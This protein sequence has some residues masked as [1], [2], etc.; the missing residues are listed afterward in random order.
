MSL[1]DC[2]KRGLIKKDANAHKRAKRELFSAEH[3]LNSAI[4][5]FEIKEYDLTVL[6][7]YN[8]CF[9][10]FRSILF[11]KGFT[12]KSHYCLIESLRFLCKG[13]EKL[14]GL[15]DEFDKI[16]MSRHEIQYRGI[17]SDDDEASYV[18]DFTK[19]LR[20]N[21]NSKKEFCQKAFDRS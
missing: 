1:E 16:R 17:F 20:K 11:E 10:F 7:C 3:F 9:H 6:S 14:L 18:L 19:R 5:I 21:M 2:R 4:K 15:L 13:D 8:S 12:E